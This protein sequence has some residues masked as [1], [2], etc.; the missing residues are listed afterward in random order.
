MTG[1]PVL[2]MAGG[3]GGHVFP[4]LALARLLRADSREVI[5]LGTRRG[6]EARVVP[7]EGIP[8]EWLSIG[9]L[10]G[11][12]LLTLLAA[13]VRLAQA[14]FEALAVMRRHRP[15]VVVGLGG[16]V[17]GPGGVAAWLRRRPL[18]V[19]EQNAV[20]GFT[21]R[22][23]ARLARTVLTAF[24]AV[25]PARLGA[26]EIGNPVREDIAALPAPAAR[27]AGR[28]GALRI[29]VVGGSL[30]AARL[31]LALPPAFAQLL[32]SGVALQIRHQAGERHVD[33]ARAAYQAAQ[34]AAE[35]TPFIADMAAAYAWA[36]LVVCRAGALT[37]AELSAAGIGALLVPYPH[38]VDDHQTR[39][40]AHLVDA[41]AALC[42]ADRELDAARAAAELAPL[43][44]DRGRLLAMA[45]AARA[46]ARPEA[47]AEL[48]RHSLAAAGESARGPA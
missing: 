12:G 35:V 7:A 8:V 39:N 9:G 31:N 6:I 33:A 30:G 46:L 13:P 17:S 19:H 32:A 48:M 14:L 47:A 42:V 43:C 28:G 45:Q 25:F 23:L 5:W 40:A 36:D 15:S 44:A 29:L 22:C 41:G 11:K 1:R 2:I 20:A 3:T 4:A 37:I 34:V 27:F 26:I 21:N 10:R 38:A 16:F 24:P 18:V